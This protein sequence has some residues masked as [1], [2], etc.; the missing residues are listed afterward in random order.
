VDEERVTVMDG[1]DKFNELKEKV[2][3]TVEK[4]APKAIA[5]SDDLAA[6]PEV[7][8][9]EFESS[10]KHVSLLKEAGFEVEYPF[11]GIDT[12]F[13]AK[14]GNGK[15]K[16]AL[17]VEYDA[18]PGI[19]HAC[20][21][22]IHGAM[23]NLAGL[24][25]ASIYENVNGEIQVIGTPAEETNG[26]KIKMAEDGVF[27][28]LDLAIMLHSSG[29]ISYVHYEALAM[30]AIEFDFKGKA[31]HAASFPWEGKNA[32]NGVQL[33]FHAI[34]MLRQHV[35]PEV[36]MHG[37]VSSG[38]EAPNIVPEHASARFYFRA[39]QRWLVDEVVDK[40]K[41]C[42]RGAALATE[43]EVHWDKFELSFDDMIPNRAAEEAMEEIMRE[44]GVALSDSPG[45]QGSSDIGNVSHRCPALQP[46]FAITKDRL[47][48]HTREF[49]A[50]TRTEEAHKA[51]VVGAKTL[52]AMALRTLTDESLRKT[53]REI[54]EK[55]KQSD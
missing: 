20:G 22:N 31:S 32:L 42:A 51:L 3:E 5:L 38:G 26:A 19:G 37:I 48:V 46:M 47:P 45:P 36:R 4:L 25:L 53:M 41:N 50:A 12:A 13:R 54:F 43:T 8:E 55:E 2:Y 27:D 17:L 40:A 23:A 1:K 18:L 15:P 35:V 16:V 6:H 49:E 52:A 24:A 29:G 30:D 10:R 21:H 44:L 39:P 33:L 34:D 9:K 28:D 11:D 14:I 7:S